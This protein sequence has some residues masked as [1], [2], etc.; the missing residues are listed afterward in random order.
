MT[1]LAGFKVNPP[2]RALVSFYGYGDIAGDW[3]S[4]PDPF[5]CRAPSP[6]MEEV[7]EFVGGAVISGSRLPR[8]AFYLYCRQNGLW[9]KEIT[10]F[11]PVAE[12]DAYVPFQTVLNVT[13]EYPPNASSPRRGRYR[14]AVR[15]I[16][17]D[18]GCASTCGRRVRITDLP[19]CGPRF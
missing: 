13:A 12:L 2:P 1:L 5:Y 6:S 4:K 9:S 10:G 11:D 15:A 14:R 8:G 7:N 19:G 18:G 17:P 16:G 3:L